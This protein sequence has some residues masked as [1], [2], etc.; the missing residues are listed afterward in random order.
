MIVEP[1]PVANGFIGKVV[2]LVTLAVGGRAHAALPIL[3]FDGY[4]GLST[5]VIMS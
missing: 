1:D 4:G 5:G 3:G 2:M